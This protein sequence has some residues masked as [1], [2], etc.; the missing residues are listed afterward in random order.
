MKK[1]IITGSE[2]LIG[3]SLIKFFSSEG[4]ECL[5]L[6][7]SLGHDLTDEKFVKS[8][9]KKNKANALINLFALNHHIGG[10]TTKTTLFDLSLESFKQY[11]NV[12][13]AA[14]FCVCREF[15]ANN[16]EGNIVNFAST[17]GMVSPRKDLYDN[18]EK[19]IGYSV[20]KAAVLML[21]RHLAT[22]LSPTFRVNTVVPGGV[23]NDHNKIFIEKYSKHTPLGR[24]MRVNELHGIVK[25][26]ISEESSYITG[27]EFKV[28][29]GWTAW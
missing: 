13:V 28:D 26:L 27:A 16:D 21:T 18:E 8:Y 10:K 11:L 9:F 19:H 3:S 4:Y 29:G 17:Y 20:S 12:N 14:L 25:L 7:L 6:D 2:G 24:M 1:I 15:A 23:F 22:H 5:G